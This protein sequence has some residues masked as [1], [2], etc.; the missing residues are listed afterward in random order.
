MNY[1]ESINPSVRGE[2]VELKQFTDNNFVPPVP[3]TGSMRI[4]MNGWADFNSFKLIIEQ[5]EPLPLHV[6]AV[7]IEQNINER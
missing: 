7:V 4:E 1:F 2:I 3:Y 5:S 6:T